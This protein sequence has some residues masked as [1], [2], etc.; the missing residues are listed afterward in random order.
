MR[1]TY[2]MTE[3]TKKRLERQ[4]E[5]LEK[6]LAEAQLA[7]GETAGPS[8]NWHDNFPFEQAVRNVDV[9]AAQV[10]EVKRKLKSVE[11]IK[12]NHN[13]EKVE[14]GNTTI[15]KFSD[16]KEPTGLTILGPDDSDKKRG[17]IPYTSPVAK[18]I[19]GKKPGEKVVA[20]TPAGKLEI[21]I[22]SILPGEFE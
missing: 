16:E 14:I 13:T 2:L 4:L 12:P 1:I 20:K 19:L 21:K 6:D 17:W 7:V 18:A 9:Y 22:L 5:K 10:E 8:H 3:T 11:I 15:V